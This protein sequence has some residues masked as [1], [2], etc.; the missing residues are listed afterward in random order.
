MMRWVLLCAV[1]AASGCVNLQSVSRF[2]KVSA[3]TADSDAAVADYVGSLERQRRMLREDQRAELDAQ[4]AE[5][6]QQQARLLAAQHVLADYLN[7][8]GELAADGVPVIDPELDA[9][10]ASLSTAKFVGDSDAQL[11][12]ATADAA[13]AITGLLARVVTDFARQA[14]IKKLLLA[15]DKP[16]AAVIAGLRE[17]FDKDL[18]AQL[19]NERVAT[20]KRF[21]AWE[22]AAK[23]AKDEDG[24]APVARLLLE[25]RQMEI[26]AREARINAYISALDTIGAGHAE[27][28]KN[29]SKLDTDDL[30]KKMQGLTENVKKSF[31][32][33]KKLVTE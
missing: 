12:T 24:A 26:D 22:A 31:N 9:L 25:E 2:A 6:R 19:Q 21:K 17:V 8:L 10:R 14:D 11:G 20:N 16:F 1:V 3:A 30:K 5:R 13:V 29:A 18:R 33:I 32:S 4:L 7:V 27:L 23:S 28:V 15:A